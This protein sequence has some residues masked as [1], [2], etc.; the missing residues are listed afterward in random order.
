MKRRDEK[1]EILLTIKQNLSRLTLQA[2]RLNCGA[3]AILSSVNKALDE[4]ALIAQVELE[5][6][7][8]GQHQPVQRI[9]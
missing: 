3:T 2:L 7:P 1:A 6:P 4:A 9:Q 8:C 5:F